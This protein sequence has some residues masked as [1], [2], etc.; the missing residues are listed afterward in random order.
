[1]MRDGPAVGQVAHNHPVRG[2]NP[3]P[4]TKRRPLVYVANE[5]TGRHPVGRRSQESGVPNRLPGRL[6]LGM[7]RDGSVGSRLAG[8]SL[9]APTGPA[10]RLL[11]A[12]SSSGQGHWALNPEVAGSNPASVTGAVLRSVRAREAGGSEWT[13][14][15]G[16]GG[17]GLFHPPTARLQD[18]GCRL[19]GRYG[20]DH[21]LER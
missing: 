4:A 17:A 7:G 3:L 2:S 11:L 10:V 19:V 5:I 20:A 12:L 13:M 14:R 1:M 16:G 9:R 18:E 6:G 15:H 8:G 21:F